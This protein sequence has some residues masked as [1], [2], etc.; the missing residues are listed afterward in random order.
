MIHSITDHGAV[1][2][3]ETVNTAAIQAAI[4]AAHVAGGGTVYLPSGTWVS[5]TLH[6]KTAVTLEVSPH[7][8]LK[9]SGEMA[10]FPA[11]KV[12]RSEDVQVASGG[13]GGPAEIEAHHF[14]M[15]GEA[16]HVSITGGGIIDGNGE[17]FWDMD[18]IRADGWIPE[19]S[20]RVSPMLHFHRCRHLR[21][22][23]IRIHNSP[24][25]TVHPVDCDH[26]VINQVEVLNNLFGPN[27][28][29]F[30]INGCRDVF[31]SNCKLTCG[32]DC[33]IIKA[34]PEAGTTERV[35]VTNCIVKT[36]CIGIGLGQETE[37][38]IRDITVSNCVMHC[39]H[40][41]FAVGLWNGGTVENVTVTNCTGDTLENFPLARPIQIEVKRHAANDNA[42]LGQ[43]RN[44]LIS[45]F[46]CRTDGRILITGEKLGTIR[47]LVLRDILL[48]V[49]LLEDAD[50]LSPKSATE[51]STQYANRNLEARRKNAL[52][53]AENVEHL[54]LENV[55][56][57]WPEKSE[58]AGYDGI[59]ARHIKGG[60]FRNPLLGSFGSGR[61]MVLEDVGVKQ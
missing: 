50:A 4:D 19:R 8:V 12:G 56:A 43:L 60:V 55:M 26:V 33:I 31:V 21:L 34:T 40:R 54:V 59:W 35:T 13:K 44:V 45:N 10:D 2:D 23:N 28:D 30:D 52:V 39:C 58:M 22:D 29:G 42:G 53:V 46:S 57:D 49:R 27:T 48:D 16:E 3:G 7:A 14:I 20:P 11:S 25:W 47:N 51:G 36:N 61:A 24:G 32:D 17:A 9:A 5:G 37:S 1:A 18:N 15:A 6:L 38:D 41:M